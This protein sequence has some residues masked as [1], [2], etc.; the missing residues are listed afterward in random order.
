MKVLIT[1]AT[2]RVGSRLAPRLQQN[3]HTVR[4]LVRKPE[5]GQ[6]FARL[7][8]DVA[9][10]DLTQPQTL[11]PALA[12]MQ[13]VVHLAAQFRGAT[14]ALAQAVNTDGTLALARAAQPAGLRQF[15]YIST[16]LVYGAGRGR[17]ARETDEP[18]PPPDRFYPVTKLASERALQQL[19]ST[20]DLGL[21]ILRLAFVYG[22]GDPHLAEAVRW[23][24]GWPARK[25]LHLVHHADVAEAILGVLDNPRALGRLYNVADDEPVTAAEI[26]RLNG[27]AVPEEQLPREV[28]D[29][30]EG[31]VD[32]T[33][34]REE[35]GFR[36]LYPSVWAAQAAHAL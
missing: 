19:Y 22:D 26:L 36:P 5:Q 17:P 23:A 12:G 25:R 30:W 34:L 18:Q 24:S 31:I 27:L 16:N 4:V 33:R 32:T 13:A 15:I 28:D 35:L 8:L 20:Q 29:P 2:G 21:T 7:G 10:G 14:P 1:G 9:V 3:G 6:A 11:P